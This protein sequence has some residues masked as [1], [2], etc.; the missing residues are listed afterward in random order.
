[1]PVA[2]DRNGT[3]VL[4]R[5]KCAESARRSARQV[6]HTDTGTDGINLIARIDAG[7]RHIARFD[8]VTRYPVDLFGKQL[9]PG[10]IR[11]RLLALEMESDPEGSGATS[12]T[13]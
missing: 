8:R 1:M 5:E 4:F 7:V 2:E 11:R 6:T 10:H 9:R 12:S 3:A 13:I